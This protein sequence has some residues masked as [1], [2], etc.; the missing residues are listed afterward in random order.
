MV[1]VVRQPASK[2][3]IYLQDSSQKVIQVITELASFIR[4][5]AYHALKELVERRLPKQEREGNDQSSLFRLYTLNGLC[6]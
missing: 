5:Q 2:Q 3:F 1:Q 6:S 4:C